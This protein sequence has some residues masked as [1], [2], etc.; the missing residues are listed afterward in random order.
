MIQFYIP[1]ISNA[2]TLPEA[3]SGHCVRVLRMSVGD[4]IVC[5]DGNG[6]RYQ[7]RITEAHPKHCAVE[8]L[9]KQDIAP[10]WGVNIT[11][12]FAPTKNMDRIEWMAEKCTE[13]GVDRLIPVKCAHSER[14][15]LKTERL[16]KILVSAMKQSLKATLPRLDELQPLNEVLTSDFKGEKFICYCAE[17]IP[18]KD[19][20]KEYQPGKDVVV[21]IGPEGDFSPEEVRI[22]LENGWQAVTLGESRLRTETAGTVA[23]AEIHTINRLNR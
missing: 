14:K 9:S 11:L 15:E 16:N 4:E 17:D 22:A 6:G 12:C 19:F 13:I 3:E 23:V 1:D 7:C 21:L 10:H 2:T 20:A 18:R 8:I 5:V